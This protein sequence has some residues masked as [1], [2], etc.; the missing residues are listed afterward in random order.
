MVMEYIEDC[1]LVDVL[2]SALAVGAS[3]VGPSRKSP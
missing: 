1:G 2:D 3:K